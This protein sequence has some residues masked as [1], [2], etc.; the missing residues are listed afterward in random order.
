MI[1]GMHAVKAYLVKC[2]IQISKIVDLV[3]GKLNTQNRITLG[4]LLISRFKKIVVNRIISG[5]LVVLDV[6]QRDV[7]TGLIELNVKNIN[8]FNW[9]CQLRYYW[10]VRC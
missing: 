9:L 1:Q 7:L 10:Q 6:H 2:N 5:A 3:R 4:K 8:D